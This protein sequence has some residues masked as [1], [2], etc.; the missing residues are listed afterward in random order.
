MKQQNPPKRYFWIILI[1]LLAACATLP[2]TSQPTTYPAGTM[3]SAPTLTP[4]L[5]TPT[6]LPTPS[7]TP[8]PSFTLDG[9]R[10]A[11]IIKGNLYVQ[12]S[13]GQPVQLTNSGADRAPL[14]SDDGQKIVFYRGKI[15][16]NNNVYSVDADG[17]QE[18]ALITTD[19]LTVLGLGTKAGHLA[20]VPGTH[21]L[22]FNTY[23]C[24]P[25]EPANVGCTTGL[26]LT[27]VDAGKIKELLAPRLGGHLP[28]NGNS[29]WDGNY[30]QVSP[31]G[32]LLSVAVSGHIDLFSIDGQVI[33]RNIMTYTRSAP[34]ELLPSQYW[35]PD[36][37]G[38][39]VALPAETDFGFA[40]GTTPTYTIWRYTLAGNVATQIPFDPSPMWVSI[41][42]DYLIHFSPDRN[43]GIYKR[44]ANN[45]QLYVGNLN[46]GHSQLY[47]QHIEC[48]RTS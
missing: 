39:V 31:D 45:V 34:D 27:D 42:C 20:F 2:P 18:Q 24:S 10:V 3:T 46:D 28:W 21:Q 25:Q 19:W 8:L 4:V 14:F 43:W 16:D 41:D 40:Y 7:P 33:R 32:K 35:L 37:S 5:E 23:L 11:Y 44:L 48:P 6:A 17:S 13:G 29:S 1:T 38:L 15:N 30:F 12:D 47:A 9:L 26:F 22:L 36:S